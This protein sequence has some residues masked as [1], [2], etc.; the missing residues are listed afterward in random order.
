VSHA[1]DPTQVRAVQRS[2]NKHR[3]MSGLRFANGCAEEP[4]EEDWKQKKQALGKGD[5]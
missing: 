4:K 2:S 1:H 3:E 5:E